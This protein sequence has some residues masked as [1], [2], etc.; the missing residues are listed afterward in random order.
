MTA[1]YKDF[2]NYYRIEVDSHDVHEFNR[3]FTIYYK[4]LSHLEAYFKHLDKVDFFSFIT[5]KAEEGGPPFLMRAP[6]YES[7][8]VFISYNAKKDPGVYS[9]THVRPGH[10]PD[11]FSLEIWKPNCNPDPALLPAVENFAALPTKDQLPNNRLVKLVTDELFIRLFLL[12]CILFP[13]EKTINV[14][15]QKLDYHV[16]PNKSIDFPL[17]HYVHH[18]PMNMYYNAQRILGTKLCG[19]NNIIIQFLEDY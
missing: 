5:S 17:D 18:F 11:H 12:K 4:D 3:V 9:L 14:V 19:I 7:I 16:A 1:N 10:G 8:D 13:D 2:A 6:G 15:M